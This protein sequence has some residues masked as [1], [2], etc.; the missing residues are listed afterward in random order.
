MAL[1]STSKCLLVCA[2]QRPHLGPEWTFVYMIEK[3]TQPL[4]TAAGLAGRMQPP[5]QFVL[6]LLMS[7]DANIYRMCS[8]P[9][10]HV[11]ATRLAADRQRDSFI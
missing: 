10:L 2:Q 1:D 6:A 8:S 4:L 7:A 11:Y 5:I 9:L 3:P